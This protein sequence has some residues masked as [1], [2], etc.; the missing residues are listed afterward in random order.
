MNDRCPY[1]ISKKFVRKLKEMGY[2][3]KTN[4]LQGEEV[5]E[6]CGKRIG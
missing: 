5:F 1:Y 3:M 6:N 4:C 2:N